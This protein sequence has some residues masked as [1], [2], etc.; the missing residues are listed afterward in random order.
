MP[1][2]NRRSLLPIILGLCLSEATLT[3][4][5][6]PRSA[7]VYKRGVASMEAGNFADAYCLWK[8]L[9]EQGYSEAQYSLGWM[10]ANGYGLAMD[11]AQ[12]LTWWKRAAEHGH[13]DAQF[14]VAMA[15]MYGDGVKQDRDVASQWL[16]KAA[17][18]GLEDA[19][20]ILLDMAGRGVDAAEGAVGKLLKSGKWQALG[21]AAT[22]KSDRANVRSGPG[23]NYSIVVTLDKGT[24]LL[25]LT[26]KGE[27]LRA[28]IIGTGEL[29]WVYAPLL[30]LPDDET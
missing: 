16:I 17:A 18:A 1:A 23:T 12:A 20:V 25:V 22:I 13:A 30:S 2:F 21:K 3:A 29:V 15:Y 10:Y 14:A 8:P 9:A 11:E 24:K 27:W 6:P 4:T 19:K 26:H 7:D 28:G 5:P